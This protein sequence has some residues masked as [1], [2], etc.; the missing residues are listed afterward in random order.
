VFVAVASSSAAMAYEA[1]AS[2]L[3]HSGCPLG[4]TTCPVLPVQTNCIQQADLE[5]V[6]YQQGM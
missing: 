5:T 4:C 6:C 3:A 1:A 2:L